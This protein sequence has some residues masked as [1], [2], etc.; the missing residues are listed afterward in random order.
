VVDLKTGERLR[1]LEDGGWDDAEGADAPEAGAAQETIQ[2]PDGI[3]EAEMSVLVGSLY[4]KP[5]REG[6]A[7]ELMSED[8]S[9][10]YFAI[11]DQ[12]IDAGYLNKSGSTSKKG[13]AV[14]EAFEKQI[15]G[16][17]GLTPWI[18]AQKKKHGDEIE[19]NSEYKKWEESK[20]HIRNIV[21]I[22]ERTYGYD[23]DEDSAKFHGSIPVMPPFGK[24]E[25]LDDNDNWIE[26]LGDGS[27][28]KIII[29][30]N[31]DDHGLVI[32]DVEK[33]TPKKLASVIDVTLRRGWG[34]SQ[35]YYHAMQIL[36]RGCAL[37][38]MDV[39]YGNFDQSTSGGLFD[40]VSGSDLIYGI[41]AQ[42]HA[43]GKVL[44]R[45]SISEDGELT[46]FRGASDQDV[47]GKPASVAELA[48]LL[49][50]IK[51][52]VFGE[53]FHGYT[54]R[55]EAAIDKLMSEKRGEVPDAFV[56]PEL[57][58]IAFVYGNEQMGLR[59]IEVRRGM[60]WVRRIPD[61]LRNGR[62]ERDG[63]GLPQV[64][65][66]DDA[67]P[68]HVA[69]VRLDWFGEEKT[70]LLTAYPDEKN[71]W[72][73]GSKTIGTAADEL[74]PV[75]GNPSRLNPHE[76]NNAKESPDEPSKA[77]SE[78]P[79]H[80]AIPFLDSPAVAGQGNANA[81][82]AAMI[83]FQSVI[84]GNVPDILAPELADE[85]EAAYLPVQG[86]PEI[87]ALFER[88]VDAYQ[89]AMLAATENLS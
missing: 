3:S 83:L 22:L 32:G 17:E 7:T 49:R 76:D 73:G 15:G 10:R 88:A 70:W 51:A 43:N 57:G 9:A 85:M 29:D 65:I 84:D 89:A 41:T 48:E 2:L 75:Q 38:G 34:K 1:E 45:A 44:A 30:E 42:L 62:V 21:S 79:T 11:Q 31:G 56:H 35:P 4:K 37:A 72:S 78:R 8:D 50:S 18:D 13:M 23:S 82:T 66:V 71:K 68:A 36:E 58:N 53:I 14:L 61:I 80:P 87:E 69:V 27:L 28:V 63:Q 20:K 67:N 25:G 24:N 5:Y 59:H 81:K 12:L 6:A 52:G 64:F 74:E 47:V 55:P 54:N 60:E 86:D 33:E 46:I 40:T 16:D 19:Q 77:I 39:H 26:V